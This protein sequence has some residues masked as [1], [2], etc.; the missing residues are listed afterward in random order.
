MIVEDYFLCI[1]FLVVLDVIRTSFYSITV[2]E[3]CYINTINCQ[4]TPCVTNF[5]I[6]IL[7]QTLNSMWEDN[8]ANLAK[9]NLAV[10]G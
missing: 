9:I 7:V 1:S 2:V 4:S 8:I 10:D 5:R 3:G 6:V